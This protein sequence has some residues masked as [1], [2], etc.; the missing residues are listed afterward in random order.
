MDYNSIIRI[1]DSLAKPQE[2]EVIEDGVYK[3]L[4]SKT[5]QRNG[6]QTLADNFY[7]ALAAKLEGMLSINSGRKGR[8]D[9]L[10]PQDYNVLGNVVKFGTPKGVPYLAVNG[11]RVEAEGVGMT[12]LQ[13]AIVELFGME[14]KGEVS[15]KRPEGRT[16]K[17]DQMDFGNASCKGTFF[18]RLAP[19]IVKQAGSSRYAVKGDIN[20]QYAVTAE[21]ADA[22]T[23]PPFDKSKF[24][25]RDNGYLRYWVRKGVECHDLT[26]KLTSALQMYQVVFDPDRNLDKIARVAGLEWVV[27]PDAPNMV[28]VACQDTV[29]VL[30]KSSVTGWKLTKEVNNP[31]HIRLR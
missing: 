15:I 8:N 28:V 6:K 2:L 25:A 7:I 1:A 4:L 24:E 26:D 20:R 23:E 22:A 13:N 18:T 30:E 16:I 27:D 21:Q 5:R 11:K 14:L 29:L 12:F 10:Y 19:K 3:E 9:D 17:R 31:E